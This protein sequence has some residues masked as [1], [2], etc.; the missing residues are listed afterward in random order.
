VR[1]P[2]LVLILAAIAC[3]DHSDKADQAYGL[4]ADS[5][6]GF[7]RVAA[8]SNADSL[9]R[10]FVERDARGEFTRSSAWFDGA[11]DCPGHEAA[12]HA[13][14]LIKSYEL[15]VLRRTSDSLRAEVLWERVGYSGNGADAMAPGTDRDTLV[16]VHTAFGWRVTSP[17]LRPHTPVPPPPRP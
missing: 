14:T 2:V 7:V 12:P 5:T 16:V 10:E 1:I 6:C 8:H 15:R 9:L 4:P 3:V 17:A 11:V 13:A